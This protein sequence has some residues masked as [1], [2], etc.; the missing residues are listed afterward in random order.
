MRTQLTILTLFFVIL[1]AACGAAAPVEEGAPT[2]EPSPSPE[3]TALLTPTPGLPL[4]VLLVPVDANQELSQ[5]YQ[6]AIYDLAQREGMRFQILNSLDPANLDPALKVVIA[7]VQDPGIAALAAAAPQ[8][9]F[10]AVNIPGITAGGN[11]SVLGGEGIRIDQQAFMAGYIGAMITEDYHTGIIIR[12]DDALGRNAYTAF[13]T[14]QEFF[15]GLCNPLAGPFLDYPLVIEIPA[16]AKPNEYGAY[17]DYLIRNKVETMFIQD[18]V[19]TPELL[20][21]LNTVGIFVI[22]M[23][24]P[25]VQV[26]GWVVTLQPNYLEAMQSV[27]PQL[28]AGNGGQ[29]FQAPL[30]LTDI[31]RDVFTEG[32]EGQARQILQQLMDGFIFTGVQ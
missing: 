16:D 23:Q 25:P 20:E 13:Q 3:P 15:C 30:T 12:K 26:N 17:A 2:V 22:G 21:Y 14:G 27:W 5:A 24:T 11:V 28:V 18:V 7:L 19:A 29:N 8:A 9:Q 31:N 32:K 10:L 6:T 4:A 1:L